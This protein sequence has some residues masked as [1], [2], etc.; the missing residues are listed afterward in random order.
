MNLTHSHAYW[1]FTPD[2]RL[3]EPVREAPLVDE[4]QAKRNRTL[5]LVWAATQ[6]DEDD[7]DVDAKEFDAAM[8]Y[9]RELEDKVSLLEVQLD[10]TRAV[11]RQTNDLY[12][13]MKRQKVHYQRLWLD[14]HHEITAGD[15]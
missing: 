4:R 13:E 11:V 9:T 6:G 3:R 5:D 7:R 8:A 12:Q 10:Q 1:T 2:G 15:E 14:L